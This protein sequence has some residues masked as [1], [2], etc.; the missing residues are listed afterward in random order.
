[1]RYQVKH[2]VDE[3]GARCMA[4]DGWVA[5]E[6]DNLRDAITGM[7]HLT[8]NGCCGYICDPKANLNFYSGV[9]WQTI[10]S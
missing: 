5:F 6:T 4:P 2:T 1:M 9:G 10:A 3:S 8:A 7:N